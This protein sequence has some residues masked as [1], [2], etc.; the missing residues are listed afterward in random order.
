M[1]NRNTQFASSILTMLGSQVAV[2]IIG[3]LYRLVITN[4]DGFG[5]LGNGYYA[6][7]FQIY[8]LLLAI[9]SVG[10]PSA[11]SKLVA[12]ET[13]AGNRRGAYEVFRTALLV[14]FVIGLVCSVL[15]YV[16]ADFLAVHIIQM[17]GVQSTLR[18]MSPAVLFVCLSSV[19]RGYFM[20]LGDAGPTGRS[21][22]VEQFC[23]A[24]LTILFVLNLSS[25]G[26]EIMAAS[27][28]F[29]TSAAALC[30]AAYLAWFYLRSRERR[31]NR[32]SGYKGPNRTSILRRSRSILALSVPVSLASIIMS[33]GRVIDTG[34]IS[35]GIS[36]AF[37][38]G[39]PGQ[40]GI[41][42]T[43][44]LNAEAIRLT[45]MLSKGDSILNL[46]LAL[47]IAFATVLVPTVSSALASGQK[48]EARKKIKF[49]LLMSILFILPCS[50][51]LIV[52]AEPIYRLIYPNALQGWEL[53]QVAAIGMIF[54]A[55]S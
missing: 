17:D 27:A 25:R 4:I 8:T 19:I 55:L 26:P 36:A 48:H 7:G 29:A 47:N 31:Q 10:I 30:S 14:F 32:R 53:L 37:A 38:R 40:T 9:S 46:P 3:L 6:A 12:A 41:P 5:D 28:N 35:R 34:T 43:E 23:K 20:G 51:G 15:M 39:I 13:A 21:Q 24:V 49:S 54:A 33:V 50:V 2:K 18:A 44:A 42:G 52:L 22:V 45:G 11:I 1:K 16:G